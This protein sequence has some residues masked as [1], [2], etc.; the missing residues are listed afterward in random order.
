MCENLFDP[1]SIIKTVFSKVS[2]EAPLTKE[3]L[4]ANLANIIEPHIANGDLNPEMFVSNYVFISQ[5]A[6]SDLCEINARLVEMRNLD[7]TISPS[8]EYAHKLRYFSDINKEARD[9]IISF[10]SKGLPE[11]LLEYN[12][13]DFVARQNDELLN[14]R[15]QQCYEYGFFKRYFNYKY[16]FSTEAKIR[17]IPG[18]N[19]TNYLECIEKYIKLKA[20]SISDYKDEISRMVKKHDVLSYLCNRVEVHNVMNKRLE[21][22]DTMRT[23]YNQQKWQ[24]FISL[25]VLQIE[26]LFYDCCTVMNVKTLSRTAGSLVEKVDKSFKDNHILML[27]VYPYYKFDIPILRNEIAHTGLTTQPDLEYLANELIL[28]LNTVISLIY[29]HSH[30]KYKIILMISEAI[31]RENPTTPEDDANVLLGEMLSCMAIANFD[32]LDFLKSPAQFSDEIKYMKAPDGYWESISYKL[33]SIIKTKAFWE[34]IEEQI[35]ITETYDSNKPFNLVVLADK[36]KNT[37]IPILD[38]GS[39]EKIACQK[40]AAKIQQCKNVAIQ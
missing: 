32:Y 35:R 22:F 8:D 24:S 17:F 25:A 38:N 28:D 6:I 20:Q 39:P 9:K 31:D 34:K 14:L 12:K 26:G 16:D 30:D 11:L 40:V 18:V 19:I 4:C 29:E 13:V 2:K 10:L 15:L 7:K 5:K 33:N 36:L 37:F 27:S 1:S 23:L 21:I 3:Q